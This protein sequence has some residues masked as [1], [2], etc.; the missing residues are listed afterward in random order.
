MTVCRERPFRGVGPAARALLLVD[1]SLLVVLVL[2]AHAA[3]PDPSW[4]A[5]IYDEADH[6][7]IVGILTSE[8]VALFDCL[9]PEAVLRHTRPRALNPLPHTLK[10]VSVGAALKPRSPPSR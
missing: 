5:G 10:T 8:D 6:D 9:G 3:P 1:L 4:L 2:L 7:D